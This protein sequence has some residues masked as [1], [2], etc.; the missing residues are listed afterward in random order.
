[1]SAER[2]GRPIRAMSGRIMYPFDPRPD[3]IDIDDIAHALAALSRYTGH[4]LDPVSVAQHSVYVSRHVP[5]EC[6]FPALLHDAAEAYLNDIAAPNKHAFVVY[7]EPFEVHEDRLLRVI[8]DVT[9]CPWPSAAEWA[10][11]KVVDKGTYDFERGDTIRCWNPREAKDKFLKR[12]EELCHV[13]Y[14]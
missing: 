10:A 14:G 9:G 12:F 13:R 5:R 8:F 2:K 4:T 6:A 3:E 11:I 1:M 7:G